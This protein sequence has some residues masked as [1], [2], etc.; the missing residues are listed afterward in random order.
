[1][2]KICEF[3]S[4]LCYTGYSPFMPGT[5]GTIFALI[6]VL[7]FIWWKSCL[8]F[9]LLTIFVIIVGFFTIKVFLNG[10]TDDLQHIVIDEAAGLYITILIPMC[11]IGTEHINMGVLC[12]FAFVFFRIFDI[13][14]PWFIGYAD[15]TLHGALGIMVDDILA[16][17]LSGV[18]V[19][20]LILTYH[21]FKA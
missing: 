5:V 16:G 15:R 17:I 20:I 11:L 13:M 3:L 14:K 18:I 1:M 10:Q 19:S 7:P 6:L 4:T 2:K 12:I 21:F 9:A 8:V